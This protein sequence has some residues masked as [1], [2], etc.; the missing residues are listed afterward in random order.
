MAQYKPK[1]CK[2]KTTITRAGVVRNTCAIDPYANFMD[3]SCMI[4]PAG[5]CAVKK[6]NLYGVQKQR[7]PRAPRVSQQAKQLYQKQ[8]YPI[9][10]NVYQ[11][12]YKP[13][14]NV[15]QA[16]SMC[17]LKAY[18]YKDTVRTKC[19][20]DKTAK[21]MHPQCGRNINGQCVKLASQKYKKP[22]KKANVRLPRQYIARQPPLF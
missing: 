8:Y 22:V 17:N 10:A 13:V 9:A 3:S 15:Y 1:Y 5:R 6:D 4:T 18:V 2:M 21:A 14:A 12:Q 11:P 19:V 7:V 16:P 20:I